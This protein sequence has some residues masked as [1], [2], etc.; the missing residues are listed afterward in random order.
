[1]LDIEFENIE[2]FNSIFDKLGN[3]EVNGEYL[4]KVKNY[5]N[6]FKKEF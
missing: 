1:M 2:N 4:D 6:E 5:I 3:L